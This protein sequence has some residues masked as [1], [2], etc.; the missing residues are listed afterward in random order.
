MAGHEYP[1]F[2]QP[3]RAMSRSGGRRGE[4]LEG[5]PAV[6]SSSS[7]AAAASSSSSSSSPALPGSAAPVSIHPVE[8]GHGPS[9]PGAASSPP[10]AGGDA[11]MPPDT[12]AVVQSIIDEA[13]REHARY[14][15]LRERYM[16]AEA[17]KAEM[18]DLRR[19]LVENRLYTKP[20]EPLPFE[21]ADA[22][23]ASASAIVVS[24]GGSKREAGQEAGQPPAKR[25]KKKKTNQTS[26]TG[27][28]PPAREEGT[29]AFYNA[30]RREACLN[31]AVPV[32]LLRVDKG[33]AKPVDSLFCR[34]H[35]NNV[36]DPRKPHN[37]VGMIPHKVLEH[38]ARLDPP[39]E[40]LRS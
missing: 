22:E 4:G 14:L 21:D 8:I 5:V 31:K 17:L 10:A 40:L 20:V 23:G 38:R 9:I 39:I 32:V 35:L 3:L 13:A 36:V 30:K 16:E 27:D 24:P 28:V 37:G 33:P 2:I 12:M 11:V 34:R 25:Q 6:G 26:Y 18:A 29:C 7:A 15:K 19:K 1:R